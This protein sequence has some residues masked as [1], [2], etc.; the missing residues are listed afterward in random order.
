[1]WRNSKSRRLLPDLPSCEILQYR[2]YG[3]SATIDS[4]SQKRTLT[5]SFTRK[6]TPPARGSHTLIYQRPLFDVTPRNAVLARMLCELFTDA[7][8]EDVY[9]ASLAELSFSLNY[10]GDYISISAGGFSDKLAVLTETMLKKLVA[11]EVD[12]DRFAKIV[13][14]VGVSAFHAC[15]GLTTLAPI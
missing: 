7:T 8:T 14:Q 1:M 13:D 5:L 2:D 3:T 6:L 4:G 11:F 12:E 10:A 15:C 9:D